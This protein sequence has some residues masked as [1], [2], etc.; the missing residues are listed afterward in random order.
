[1]QDELRGL[2]PQIEFLEDSVNGLVTSSPQGA[3]TDPITAELQDINE[4]YDDLNR[5]VEDLL[6]E[7]EAASENVGE[8]QV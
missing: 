6:S 5:G 1:M 7:I 4:R 8:F 2:Q 3:D